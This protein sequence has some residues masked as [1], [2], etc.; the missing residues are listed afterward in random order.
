MN[1]EERREQDRGDEDV[2]HPIAVLIVLKIDFDYHLPLHH[3]SPFS[4]F[5]PPLLTLHLALRSLIT[6]IEAGPQERCGPVRGD[7]VLPIPPR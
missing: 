5:L 2:E 3:P 4:P 7:F 1:K 6:Q